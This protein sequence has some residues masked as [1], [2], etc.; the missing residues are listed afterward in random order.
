[1]YEILENQPRMTRKEMAEKFKGKWVF[2]VD[3]DFSLGVPTKTAIPKI[4]ADEPWEGRETG[5]Y[6]DLD[7][8]YNGKT[9][10]RSYLLNELHSFGFSEVQV[11]E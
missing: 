6:Q 10:Y 8:E 9:T 1:M 11:D 5:I 3:A 4:I 2:S 7:D